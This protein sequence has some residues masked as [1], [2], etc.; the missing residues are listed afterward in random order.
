[1]RTL[2][3]LVATAALVGGVTIKPRAN[4]HAFRGVER[5]GRGVRLEQRRD[6]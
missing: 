4:S 1:M 3:S 2:T 6:L 5:D